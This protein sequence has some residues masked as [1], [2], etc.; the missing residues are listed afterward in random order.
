MVSG[1]PFMTG[2]GMEEAM[3]EIKDMLFPD[4][5]ETE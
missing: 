5:A 3:Q 1:I 2:F 4:G